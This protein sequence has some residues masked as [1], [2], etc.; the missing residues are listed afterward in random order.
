MRRPGSGRGRRA[1]GLEGPSGM[2][3]LFRRLVT[4]QSEWGTGI[5]TA[6]MTT[7][8]EFSYFIIDK[9]KKAV[10]RGTEPP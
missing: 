7:D 8:G 6:R 2:G 4:T 1:I 10:G 9:D 5:L 3:E